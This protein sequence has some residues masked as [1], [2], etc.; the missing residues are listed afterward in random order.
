[1]FGVDK[2]TPT[3]SIS[4]GKS[5]GGFAGDDM[6]VIDENTRIYDSGILSHTL[7]AKMAKSS[8]NLY[9]L[10]V[11]DHVKIPKSSNF[12]GVNTGLKTHDEPKSQLMGLKDMGGNELEST[13]PQD[14]P[15]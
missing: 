3:A 10:S 1:M 13:Y 11:S 12:E 6:S 9:G 15:S 5:N 8:H 14:P 2:P 7:E 4:G